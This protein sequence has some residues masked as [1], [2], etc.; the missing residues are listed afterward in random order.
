MNGREWITGV[1]VFG[2][3]QSHQS[4]VK[5]AL[6]SARKVSGLLAFIK[7]YGVIGGALFPLSQRGKGLVLSG[8]SQSRVWLMEM[9]KF[10]RLQR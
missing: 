5:S 7:L 10:G 6:R 1:C 8:L 9:G 3:F 2:Q 4:R